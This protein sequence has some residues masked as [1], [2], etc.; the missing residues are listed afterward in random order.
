MKK[1]TVQYLFEGVINQRDNESGVLFGD[2]VLVTEEGF[3]LYQAVKTDNPDV[4]IVDLD[5]NATDHLAENPTLLIDLI[6]SDP[7]GG[8]FVQA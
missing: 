3:G 4:V 5:V 1:I 7:G 8:S 6:V 2:K